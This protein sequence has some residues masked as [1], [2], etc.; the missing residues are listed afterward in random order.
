G[1][2]LSRRFRALKVWMILKI[3]GTDALA[4]AIQRNIDL[5]RYL[6]Q[7]IAAEP[8]LEPLGS[9]LSIAC[10]RFR[11]PQVQPDMD[12]NDLNRRILESVI[13]KGRVF[14][15][16]TELEGRYV[17]RVCIVNFRTRPQHI[18]LLVNEVLQAG[19][20]LTRTS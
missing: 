17:L 13:P 12:L 7:R 16:P 10:F 1:L 19:R 18:D 6:D 20:Q 4:G 14:M 5:R 2:E 15:S 3:R 8:D 11:P 9:E